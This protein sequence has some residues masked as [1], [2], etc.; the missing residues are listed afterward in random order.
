MQ[1]DQR[2]RGRSVGGSEREG[3]LDSGGGLRAHKTPKQL[4][5]GSY[6]QLNNGFD[7]RADNSTHH[8]ATTRHSAYPISPRDHEI[9]EIAGTKSND[10]LKLEGRGR[11]QN[12]YR[13]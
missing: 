11:I 6:Q 8:I 10:E 3:V 7:G 1:M 5:G 4:R 2:G 12:N 9:F 13:F